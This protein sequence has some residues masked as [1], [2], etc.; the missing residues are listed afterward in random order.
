MNYEEI[1]ASLNPQMRGGDSDR[2]GIL[3][4]V[5]AKLNHPEHQYRIIHIAGTNGKGSTGS[6]IAN[7]LRAANFRVGHFSSPAM[8]DQREQIQVNG[9]MIKRT[10]FAAIYEKIKRQLPPDL[11][12]ADLTVFEWW[13]LVMLQYFADQ[14]VDWAVIE[15]GLGGQ[16]DATNAIDDPELAIITHIALDHTRILGPTIKDIARAKAGI[17][18]SGSRAVILAPHQELAAFQ[19]IQK[20]A[21][22]CQVPFLDSEKQAAVKVLDQS[23][24]KTR[25]QIKT[26]TIDL[27]SDFRLLGAFQL[28]N[29]KTALTAVD[30]LNQA[31]TEITAE[32]IKTVLAQITIPGRLQQIGMHPECFLDGAHNPD[33]ASQLTQT[34][35]Q[36][37]CPKKLVLVLG[38]LK[39]KN[40]AQMAQQYAKLNA[41]I[42]LATP[43]QPNR[44][45]PAEKLQQY[46]PNALVIA[47]AW[48]AYQKAVA[49]AGADG[50]VLVTGS[51]YLIKE[52]EARI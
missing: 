46:L 10:V 37:G 27:T 2:V 52:I 15:C 6:L 7:F 33:A 41:Q 13:T 20:K 1:I 12:T 11:S 4:R 48:T 14:K 21:Q 25:L 9:Q 36:L 19:E 44:A 17:I 47:D 31:G 16:N 28:D 22:E 32:Q 42:I 51:F 5:L 35:N 8:V 45:L 40:V 23:W 50:M 18:K 39:D 34:L 30:W 49:L 29:L 43:D 26:T 3:K 24:S 38:F